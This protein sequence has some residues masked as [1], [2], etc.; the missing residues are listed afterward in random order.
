MSWR[1][2]G[3]GFFWGGFYRLPH[4]SHSQQEERVCR[5]LTHPAHGEPSPGST[6]RCLPRAVERGIGGAQRPKDLP[7]A[8]SEGCSLV[9]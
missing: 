6:G 2:A 4:L 5:G 8:P 7:P 1:L 9:G 3:S